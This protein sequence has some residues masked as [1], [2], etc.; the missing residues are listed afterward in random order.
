M[1]QDC[2]FSCFFGCMNSLIEAKVFSFTPPPS[3]SISISLSLPLS[4]SLL[5]ICNRRVKNLGFGITRK[6]NLLEVCWLSPVFFF[7]LLLVWVLSLSSAGW[8]K[9]NFNLF[10]FMGGFESSRDWLADFLW[11]LHFF[12]FLVVFFSDELDLSGRVFL[13]LLVFTFLFSWAKIRWWL[14]CITVHRL[15]FIFV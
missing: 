15:S 3:L 14:Y 7:P 2:I 8:S 4:Q 11:V 10:L 13:F 12:S 1:K 9:M 6:S 5:L